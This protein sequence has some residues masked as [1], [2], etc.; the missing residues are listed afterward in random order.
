M[1]RNQLSVLLF[2]DVNCVCVFCKNKVLV[3]KNNEKLNKCHEVKTPIP[4]GSRD[5]STNLWDIRTCGKNDSRIDFR[6]RN[7]NHTGPGNNACKIKIKYITDSAYQQRLA[8]ELRAFLHLT[9]ST[10]RLSTLIKA[11]KVHYLHRS[12]G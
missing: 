5:Y 12:R 3:L 2:C 1:K 8:A 6:T 7:D 9:L 10:P 11:I 4:T